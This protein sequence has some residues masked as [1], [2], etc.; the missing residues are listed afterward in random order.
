M[1]DVWGETQPEPQFWEYF[2]EVS[3]GRGGKAACLG[4][5]GGEEDCSRVG[6]GCLKSG[7]FLASW[8]HQL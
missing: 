1:R 8:F 2:R 3:D 7:H 4:S 6:K 5:F